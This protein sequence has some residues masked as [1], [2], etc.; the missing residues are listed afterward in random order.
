MAYEEIEFCNIVNEGYNGFR[1][2]NNVNCS[3]FFAKFNTLSF[4]NL[5]S[6]SN[7]PFILGSADF[8]NKNEDFINSFPSKTHKPLT[9]DELELL[10]LVFKRDIEELRINF[11]NLNNSVDFSVLKV[12]KLCG[13]INEEKFNEV[14]NKLLGE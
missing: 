6:F 13:L 4:D 9:K 8:I 5:D 11:V 7:V 10:L 2:D 14:K 12:L 3:D 1:Y